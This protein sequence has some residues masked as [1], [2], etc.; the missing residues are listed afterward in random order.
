MSQRYTKI[1][2][3]SIQVIAAKQYNFVP[4]VGLMVDALYKGKF[5]SGV[6]TKVQKEG[7]TSYNVWVD[8]LSFNLNSRYVWPGDD[9]DFCGK[10]I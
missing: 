1:S 2:N 8:L 5:E 6:I 9:I 7:D 4:F 3:F 10:K